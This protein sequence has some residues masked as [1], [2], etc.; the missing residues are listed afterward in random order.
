MFEAIAKP[1][2]P[3]GKLSANQAASIIEPLQTALQNAPTPDAF[4]LLVETCAHCALKPTERDVEDIV[5]GIRLFPRDVD[6]A[7]ISAAVCANS[8]YTAQAVDLV[9]KG[10]TFSPPGTLQDHFKRMRSILVVSHAPGTK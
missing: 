8:G 6:L 1:L 10:L 7:Y 5:S 2:G 3:Q 9:D 4:T